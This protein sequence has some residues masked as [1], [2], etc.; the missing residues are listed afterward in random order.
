[1]IFGVKE[2]RKFISVSEKVDFDFVAYIEFSILRC[3]VPHDWKVLNVFLN[4]VGGL[5]VVEKVIVDY[6]VAEDSFVFRVKM[7]ER[8]KEV[9]G[10]IEE[11]VAGL[12]L[13]TIGVS[14]LIERR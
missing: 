6:D 7:R 12:D 9:E 13:K 8:D 3:V 5:D 11:L 4:Q 14:V 10:W 2:M 1:M